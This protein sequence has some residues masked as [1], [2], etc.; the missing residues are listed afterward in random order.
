MIE[1]G[2]LPLLIGLEIMLLL[3]VAVVVMTLRNL[4]LTRKIRELLDREHGGI[5]AEAVTYETYLRDELRKN[6]ALLEQHGE[7]DGAPDWLVA[8]QRFLDLELE[9]RAV[10][11]DPMAFQEKLDGGFQALLEQY[12]PSPEAAPEDVQLAEEAEPEEEEVE[13]REEEARGR[14]SDD[15]LHK[16]EMM[17]LRD[18]IG[19]QQDTMRTLRTELESRSGE[20]DELEAI[21]A[22]LDAFEAQTAELVRCIEV[23]ESE[24][25]RLKQAREEGA[26]TGAGANPEELGRLKD[27]VNDQQSTI[28]NLQGMLE[29]L[30]PEAGKAH[31]LEDMLSDVVKSNK[32]LNTCIMVLEDENQS[33]RDQLNTLEK[34]A[35]A[36]AEG[37]SADIA[38]FQQR[39]QELESLLEF[40]DATLEQLEQDIEKLRAGDGGDAATA[41]GDEEL[42][43][44]VQ[45]L[46]ALLEFKEAAI[47]ELEKQYA[48]LEAKYLELSGSD[49]PSS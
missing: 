18:L 28:G 33:L 38:A 20:I 3:L 14:V 36:P 21:V 11:D 30:R 32:E 4:A 41:G 19:H 25:E 27:M 15:E 10:A 39:I 26:L 5:K 1:L 12:R 49:L 35:A 16:K 23:L 45:E 22:Q 2:L 40:K 6:R 9:A 34:Q 7:A 29:Q 48:E 46:E 42:D 44:K 24:N 8:R 13:T 37:D 47:E 43:I 17:R 31:E